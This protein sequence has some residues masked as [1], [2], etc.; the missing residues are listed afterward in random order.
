VLGVKGEEGVWEEK[1]GG[2]R[3]KNLMGWE[4]FNLMIIRRIKK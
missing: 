1:N 4:K 3:V 2:G